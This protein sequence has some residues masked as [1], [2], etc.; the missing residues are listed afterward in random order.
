MASETAPELA[1]GQSDG[2]EEH[3][4]AC[5]EQ[6]IGPGL[7]QEQDVYVVLRHSLKELVAGLAITK[8]NEPDWPVFKQVGDRKM[9]HR[10]TR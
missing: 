9:R 2:P 1:L 7:A 4:Q 3:V 6:A 10:C 5:P 8:V